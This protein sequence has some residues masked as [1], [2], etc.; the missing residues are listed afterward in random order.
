[1]KPRGRRPSARSGAR[2]EILDV[3]VRTFAANGLAGSSIRGIASAAGVDP[4]LIHYYFES[5]DRLFRDCLRVDVRPHVPRE[6]LRS[7]PEVLGGWLVTTYL[8]LWAAPAS[9]YALR[10]AFAARNSNS[11]GA[12][13]IQQL[14]PW[15]VLDDLAARG[16][17][18][19]RRTER[20]L[21]S[22][23]LLGAALAGGS[24]R[25]HSAEH[26][27]ALGAHVGLLLTSTVAD[28]A[29]DEI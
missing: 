7:P 27:D 3:A 13:L 16:D 29:H 20:L 24:E 4:A 12:E 6:V 19:A 8:S 18:T 9:G 23:I 11:D 26:K 10:A 22:W 1:M 15:R 25:T 14:L 17:V 21:A 28:P 2:G 5:K